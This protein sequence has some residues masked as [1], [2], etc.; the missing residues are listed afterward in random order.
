[1]YCF[2]SIFPF[3]LLLTFPLPVQT[4]FILKLVCKIL[5]VL[6]N[7][8]NYVFCCCFFF[9]SRETCYHGNSTVNNHS[10]YIFCSSR[11]GF[12]HSNII[13]LPSL[14]CFCGGRDPYYVMAKVL[15]CSL[16]LIVFER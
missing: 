1:M 16:E 11:F 15:D 3:F 4:Y 9:L 14:A 8:C 6:S 12:K 7:D 10:L 2:S 5:S 13:S